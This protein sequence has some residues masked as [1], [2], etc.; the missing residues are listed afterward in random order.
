MHLETLCSGFRRAR[1]VNQTSNGYVSKIPTV[2]EPLGDAGTATGTSVIQLGLPE[3]QAGLT[4]NF[5]FIKPYGVGADATTFSF[6]VIGWRVLGENTP[7]PMWDPS[8]LAVFQATL[9]SG[10]PLV[11]QYAASTTYFADTLTVTSQPLLTGT[12]SAAAAS[13]SLLELY[14]PAN[15]DPAWVK[16][17]IYGF[18][19]LELSFTTGGSAT[20]CNA[21]LAL[22]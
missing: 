18:Q 22:L 12:V 2:T 10:L 6:K 15:G 3:G 14:D 11:G 1:S 7:L 13:L 9:E 17:P 4:Q 20:S 19:K 21:L 16:V 8:T 5:L